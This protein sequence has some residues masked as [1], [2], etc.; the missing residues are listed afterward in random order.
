MV[1][2][3][4]GIIMVNALGYFW[5][6]ALM[7]ATLDDG[8]TVTGQVVERERIPGPAGGFRI[9]LQVGNRDLYGRGLRLGRRGRGSCAASF[10]PRWP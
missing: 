9:K 4:V 8:K 6:A 5:P 2:G 7:R 3:L 10:L 1:A